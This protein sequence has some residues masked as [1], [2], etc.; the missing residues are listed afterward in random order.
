MIIAPR[1][2]VSLFVIALSVTTA[3][4]PKRISTQVS[5][6]QTLTVLLAD[7]DTN[8]AG[9]ARV[10]NAFGG[11]DLTEARDAALATSDRAPVL[12]K[13]SADEVERIFGDALSALPPPPRRFTVFFR[14]ESDALTDESQALIPQ[15]LKAVNEHIVKDVV[16]IGHTDTMGTQPANF[17]LGLKRAMTVRN[18]LVEAGLDGASVDV[19]SDGELDL[20]VKTPDETPEPR[21]RRVVITVR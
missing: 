20:L 21:N 4:G 14:F 19:T 8:T 3:C 16:V 13:V 1:A 9:D 11:V 5:S 17:A 6:P 18:L 12:T 15:I 10:A 7:S 2:A